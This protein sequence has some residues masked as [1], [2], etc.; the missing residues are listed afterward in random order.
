MRL[1]ENAIMISYGAVMV[2]RAISDFSQEG[3]LLPVSEAE[4]RIWGDG[5]LDGK[6]TGMWWIGKTN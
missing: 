4:E 1:D 5:I 3:Q 2:D 6:I